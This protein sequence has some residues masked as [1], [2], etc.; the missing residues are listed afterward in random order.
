[1]TTAVSY[2]NLDE[3]AVILRKRDERKCLS[4]MFRRSH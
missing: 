3:A 2:R 4:L 1:M